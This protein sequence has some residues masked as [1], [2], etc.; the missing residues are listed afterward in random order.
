MRQEGGWASARVARGF[1][2]SLREGWREATPEGRRAWLWTLIVGGVLL[3][4]L[5]ALVASAGAHYI[6]GGP[7]PGEAALDRRILA[8]VPFS[9]NNALWLQTFGTDIPLVTV[10]FAT[11]P[12][13]A[14]RHRTLDCL[15]ILAA[16]VIAYGATNVAWLVWARAR[17][18]LVLGGAAAPGFSSFPSGHTAK[19]FAVY[20][21]LALIWAR[22]TRSVLERIVAFTLALLIGASVG[23]GRLRLGAH[24]PSDIVAGAIVGLLTFLIVAIALRAGGR[25]GTR[26]GV[27]EVG[28]ARAAPG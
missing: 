3:C 2:V 11:M 4:I 8:R 20:S 13:L 22:S 1:F 10:L 15:S 21:T 12:P 16:Y 23:L 5:L 18:T 6:G 14:R 9:F 28:R 27:R 25:A 24:W 17:P 26:G 7:M 19:S